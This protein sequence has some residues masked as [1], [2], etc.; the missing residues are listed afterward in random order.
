MTLTK[1][2][3]EVRDAFIQTTISVVGNAL[4]QVR[5]NSAKKSYRVILFT[6]LTVNLLL[7]TTVFLN[8]EKIADFFSNNDRELREN[9]LEIL[10][11]VSSMLFFFL[12]SYDG[13]GYALG[14]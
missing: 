12:S 10:P 13:A 14:L 4:G 8:K 2:D 11:L 3:G 7:A 9:L 1:F 6:E 5:I